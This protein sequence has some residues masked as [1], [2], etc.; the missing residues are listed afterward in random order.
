METIHLQWTD[1]K[2]LFSEFND[3][4]EK[5]ESL[6]NDAKMNLVN[7]FFPNF[8]TISKRPNNDFFESAKHDLNNEFQ[9][10]NAAFATI[11]NPD[12]GEGYSSMVFYANS[13]EV[14]VPDE[15]GYS[16]FSIDRVDFN[17]L[18]DKVLKGIMSIFQ[19]FKK[20]IIIPVMRT[21]S[22]VIDHF[23]FNGSRLRNFFN[24]A[25]GWCKKVAVNSIVTIATGIK[26]LKE[27]VTKAW[28]Y[29]KEKVKDAWDH[30]KEKTKN[31]W[32]YTKEKANKA[33]EATKKAGTQIGEKI[34][35]GWNKLFGK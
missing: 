35:S 18:V 4:I 33:W 7:S 6:F 10:N 19:L 5:A 9:G 1:D 28:D 31:A 8:E 21:V 3:I 24:T 32:D 15:N 30:T 2:K 23:S 25:I 14:F 20:K 29:T 27:K 16:R 17:M 13:N 26:T 12:S 22:N 11:V 34:K